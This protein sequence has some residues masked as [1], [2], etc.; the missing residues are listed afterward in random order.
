MRGDLHTEFADFDPAEANA[1]VVVL[2]GDIGITEQLE[3]CALP[4]IHVL[5]NDAFELDGIRWPGS[6]PWSELVIHKLD[7][8]LSDSRTGVCGPDAPN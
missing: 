6:T 1:D 4:S 5:N 3:S 2:A 7:T 8:V